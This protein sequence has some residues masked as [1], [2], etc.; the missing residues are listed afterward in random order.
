MTEGIYTRHSAGHYIRETKE[1]IH[2]QGTISIAW[3]REEAGQLEGVT[4][5]GPFV[6]SFTI[7]QQ[8]K[9]WY[10]PG[11]YVLPNDQPPVC[12]VEQALAR[13]QV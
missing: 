10:V 8:W 1:D 3:P 5:Y 6:A 4:N 12:W 7:T 13:F 9:C 11:A 2:Y